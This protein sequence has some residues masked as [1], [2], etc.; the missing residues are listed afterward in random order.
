MN[1]L[2]KYNS[3]RTV[4]CKIRDGGKLMVFKKMR[5]RYGSVF[6]ICKAQITVPPLLSAIM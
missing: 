5:R 6:P 2:T 3:I 4:N 1:N